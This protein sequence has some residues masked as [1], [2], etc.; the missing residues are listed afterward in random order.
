MRRREQ[1]DRLGK[2]MIR[3]KRKRQAKS[4]IEHK[5]N[6]RYMSLFPFLLFVTNS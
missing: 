6:H 5:I 4:I 2:E 1:E 3:Q